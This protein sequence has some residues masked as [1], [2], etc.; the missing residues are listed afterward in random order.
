[1]D[2]FVHENTIE[3]KERIS[4]IWKTSDN[5][6]SSRMRGNSTNWEKKIMSN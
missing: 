4:G 3:S 2:K 1:M 5:D 6:Q